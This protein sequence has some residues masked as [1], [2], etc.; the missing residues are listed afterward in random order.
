MRVY[1]KDV[2][3][4][5]NLVITER[6]EHEEVIGGFRETKSGIDAYAQTFG[7]DP[8]RSRKGFATI[9]VA[10]D[11][12][13]SFKPWEL[14]GAEGVTVEREPRTADAFETV[15]EPTPS[16]QPTES[17]VQDHKTKARWWEF[18]RSQS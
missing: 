13:E 9:D 5:Q 2:K 10:K 11:F 12:V 8:E 7:Y 15:A 16:T 17:E 1:W 4:G 3:R 6:E 18:W 14:H